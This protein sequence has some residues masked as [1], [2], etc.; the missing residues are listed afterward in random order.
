MKPV[1]KFT[2]HGWCVCALLSQ[3]TT[4]QEA[5]PEAAQ[6]TA[7][8]QPDGAVLELTVE[9]DGRFLAESG[10]LRL[11]P[12][13]YGNPFGVDVA[14]VDDVLR[15]QLDISEETG[16]VI[17]A[18]A[19]DSEAA[20]AGLKPH[21]IVLKINDQSIAGPDNFNAAIAAEQGKAVTIQ[22]LRRGQPLAI[23]ATLPKTPQYELAFVDQL[24]TATA[25]S[26]L[27]QHY[28]IGVTLAEADDTLRSQ[29][30]LA[31]GEGLV[32]TEVISDGPAAQA[33]IKPHD[34]L[35]KL[36]GRRLSTVDN[37]NAQ[38][39]EIG[40]QQAPLDFIRAG[41]ERTCD[42]TPRLSQDESPL[43]GVWFWDLSNGKSASSLLLSSVGEKRSTDAAIRWLM[44]AQGADAGA[45]E[46]P[47]KTDIAGQIE[48]L[49]RKLADIT[50]SLDALSAALQPPPSAEKPADEP[51][52]EEP[53]PE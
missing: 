11:A 39:Q 9:P 38:I 49:K 12:V 27:T 7:A 41:E 46:S 6:E 34:V 36:D 16:I 2:I 24:L 15:S 31:S 23:E 18:V 53:K 21:D 32:V 10:L 25:E 26:A 43:S 28:R 33:G 50:Q 5:A 22:G 3:I 4:A 1:L 51:Q 48:E 52:S 40:E 47:G 35:T 8:Q 13:T 17:T 45:T 42:V 20:R 29:L 37:I 14:A 44:A 19:D 30:R